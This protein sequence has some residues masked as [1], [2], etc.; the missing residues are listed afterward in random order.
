MEKVFQRKQLYNKIVQSI[1]TISQM[2]LER[3]SKCCYNIN[4]YV[5]T[6]KTKVA[7][8]ESWNTLDK[9]YGELLVEGKNVI[10]KVAE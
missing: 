5:R 3:Y 10:K 9:Y 6:D 8:E 4:N 7:D 2:G 1:K